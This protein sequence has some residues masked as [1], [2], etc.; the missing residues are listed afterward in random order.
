MDK[1]EIKNKKGLIL[2]GQKLFWS[3]KEKLQIKVF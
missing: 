2:F 3:E 1:T